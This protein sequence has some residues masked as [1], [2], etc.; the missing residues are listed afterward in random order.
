[1][2]EY[3]VTQQIIKI[4]V[5]AAAKQHAKKISRVNLVV[6][7]MSGFIGDSIQMYFEML[8]K[9]T[10]AEGAELS[11]TYIKPQ[12]KC[13]KCGITF[14]KKPYSF[15]CPKCDGQGEPSPIGKE[16]YVDSIEV[17]G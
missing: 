13:D 10:P 11:I 1:M 2:H 12:L 15:D 3:G 4:A 16:F 6:G 8:A 5:D 14:F 9:G 7:E 17:S